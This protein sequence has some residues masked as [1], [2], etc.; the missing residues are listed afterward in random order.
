[1]DV[2]IYQGNENLSLKQSDI[3]VV[4]DVIRAFT[5]SEVAFSR[6]V[7]RILLVKDTQQ[8]FS[9]KEQH[10]ER[11]LLGEVN[12]HPIPGFDFDN[13]PWRLLHSPASLEGKT[14]VQRTTNGVKAVVNNFNANLTLVTGFSNAFVTAKY[15]RDH[16]PEAS[17][18]L[19]ASHP[20]SD[21]DMACADFIKAILTGNHPES[22]AFINRIR[23]AA[24][25]EKF[26]RGA[27]VFLP[28]DIDL[29]TREKRENEF[30]MVVKMAEEGLVMERKRLELSDG[31]SH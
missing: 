23:S 29:C 12:A 30:V 18:N 15:M 24:A 16:F 10:P 13:S 21:E 6:G 26:F 5:T 3:T 14:L 20:S 19:I 17:V 7:K 31:D 28:E 25:A 9:L 8:A 22:R 27:D 2:H 4:I 11:L 1:M